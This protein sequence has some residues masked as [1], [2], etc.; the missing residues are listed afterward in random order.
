MLEI[1]TSIATRIEEVVTKVPGWS[2]IDQLLTLFIL[3]FTSAHIEGDILELGAW[4]GR[5]SVVLGMT[6]KRTG[7][8]KVYSVD[9]F[10]E[11][12]DWSMN[13]DGTYSFS[14]EIDGRK[15]RAYHEQTVWPEPFER[16][17]V[18][19][20]E[21]YNGIWDA[22]QNSVHSNN[23]EDVVIPVKGDLQIFRA[24]APENL[25]VRLAF[26]DGDHGY[27]AV[28]NDIQIAEQYLVPGGWI[29]FDD[30]FS[31]Y[32][33]VNRA[34]EEMIINNDKYANCQQLTRK[35]FAAQRI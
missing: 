28:K 17:I 23:L 11:K 33:G 32:Q 7:N 6:A 1:T 22:F 3:G 20:Y 25:K 26:I 35:M 10:P 27:E 15:I 13:A 16:D 18:P 19:V 31:T 5:S 29:C 30:A 12:K 24:K 9:L 2:P 21:K 4:C 34:I 14:V 8:T